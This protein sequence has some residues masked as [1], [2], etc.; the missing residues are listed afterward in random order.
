[1]KQTIITQLL[2]NDSDLSLERDSEWQCKG[3]L[4]T[5][6]RKHRNCDDKIF[7][8]AIFSL[9]IW[10]QWHWLDRLTYVKP[11]CWMSAQ[12]FR[13]VRVKSDLLHEI[14]DILPLAFLAYIRNCYANKVWVRI[15]IRNFNV[16]LFDKRAY[17]RKRNRTTQC[18]ALYDTIIF[19]ILYAIIKIFV[20]AFVL[21]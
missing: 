19:N 12:W 21:S 6:K 20:F 11:F 14:L 2:L 15:Q 18:T 9:P 13:R 17:S 7:Y 3:K 4:E 5:H 8:P 1:M 10:R 16:C